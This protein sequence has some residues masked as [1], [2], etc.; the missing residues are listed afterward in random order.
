MKSVSSFSTVLHS[1]TDMH[2]VF[3]ERLH[4]TE[5]M[6]ERSIKYYQDPDSTIQTL[7]INTILSRIN[8]G[9]SV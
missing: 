4:F 2:R 8:Y 7:Q 3:V 1:W 6:E 9:R 5:I